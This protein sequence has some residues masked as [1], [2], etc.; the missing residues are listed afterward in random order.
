MGCQQYARLFV[1]TPGDRWAQFKTT[2]SAYSYASIFT[3]ST[4]GACFTLIKSDWSENV[5]EQECNH[6]SNKLKH[7]RPVVHTQSAEI[8]E[9]AENRKLCL[10]DHL[11][12]YLEKTGKL[13]RGPELFISVVK[14]HVPVS[15][16]SFSQWVK[17]VLK[18]TGAD[19]DKFGSHTT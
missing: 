12:V 2:Y 19:I 14:P 13:R 15:Q 1:N 9:F 4:K 6:S 10:V 16:N 5:Q 3:H 8:L 18:D 7:T 17:M 11:R